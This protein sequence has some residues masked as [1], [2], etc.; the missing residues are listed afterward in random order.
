MIIFKFLL[1][2]FCLFLWSLASIVTGSGRSVRTFSLAFFFSYGLH[3]TQYM[4]MY[5]ILPTSTYLLCIFLSAQ[6][7]VCLPTLIFRSKH[8]H[9]YLSLSLSISLSLSLSSLFLLLSLL[10]LVINCLQLKWP[11]SLSLSYQRSYKHWG[12]SL[13]RT[14]IHTLVTNIKIC[15]PNK[16]KM[17]SHVSKY[18]HTFWP[19]T[20]NN[21]SLID[22]TKT[23]LHVVNIH[24]ACWPL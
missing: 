23:T 15:L 11:L 20:T 16:R 24:N 10:M 13:T 14:H 22:K 1:N 4:H 18:M 8:K 3:P 19:P 12:P 9:V 21:V 6:I 7:H 2:H 17:I 5:I